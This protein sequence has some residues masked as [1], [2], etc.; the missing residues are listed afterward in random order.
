MGDLGRFR[1]RLVDWLSLVVLVVWLAGW[2]GC[3]GWDGMGWDGMG[4]L[5]SWLV[6]CSLGWF[7]SWLIG[8]VGLSW[9]ELVVGWLVGWV[10]GLGCLVG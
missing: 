10:L 9:G 1:I 6:G 7:C 8:L 5:V 2:L 4:C 3:T